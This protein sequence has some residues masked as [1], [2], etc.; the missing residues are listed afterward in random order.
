MSGALLLALV[1]GLLPLAATAQVALPIQYR[2]THTGETWI[3]YQ[4][5]A[6]VPISTT[7][8][9]PPGSDGRQPTGNESTGVFTPPTGG[10]FRG[11]MSFGAIPGL[12][13]AQ[14]QTV[15]NSAI[16]QAGAT[17]FSGAVAREMDRPRG[18]DGNQ[19][20]IVLRHAQVGAPFLSREV[21]FS[22]GSV[23]STPIKDERG[24][25]L[26]PGDLATYWLPEP[27]ST[28][29]HAG[30]GYY[31]SRHARLL[32][33]IQP[34]PIFITWRKSIPYT[35]ATK[36]VGYTNPNGPASYE[37][38]G[39]NIFLLY[40][41][42][43]VVSGSPAKQPRKM[44]WTQKG[45]Q[46]TGKAILVPT[47]RIGAVNIV[48]NNS[49]PRTVTD[50]F[51]GVGSTSPVDGSNQQE[52][53]ELRTMWYE[54]Q[55]GSI[56]AYNAEGRVFVEL[57]GDLRSDGETYIPLGTE[58]VDIT[59]QPVP[60]DVT[61]EL[62]ERVIPPGD[63][64]I[65][66][67]FPEPIQSTFG[68]QY[69]FRHSLDGAPR[70]MFYATRETFNLNDY[71]IHWME[72]GEAGLRWPKHFGRYRLVWPTDV[73][74]YSHFVRPEASSDEEASQTAVLLRPE[75]APNI[76]YQDPLDRPRAKFTSDFKFYTWLDPQYPVHRALL[77]YAS[78]EN[79]AFERVFSWLD[80]SLLTTNFVGGVV[81]EPAELIAKN[82]SAWNNA[83][84]RFDWPADFQLTAPRVVKATV[85]VGARIPAPP[86]TDGADGPTYVAG[87][88]H[89]PVGTS[90]DVEAYVDPLAQGF[91]TANM[92]A[93]IPV[94]AIPGANQLEVWWFRTNTAAAGPNAGN[95]LLGFS[96]VFW[97]SVVG[98][99]TIQ[100]PSS[101]REIVLASK[102]GGVEITAIEGLGTIYTQ[103]NPALDGYNPNEEHAI[104]SAG[105]PYATRDDLNITSGPGY[106]SHPYVLVHYTD[107]DLRP[108][109]AVYKVLR[110]KPEEGFV[111][112]YV[113]PA[114][115][116]LQPPLPLPFLQKPV[117]GSGDL[118]VNYNSEPTGG[119]G[120]L[121]GGW[122][123]E[124]ASGSYSNY[125]R[126]T[127][128][129]RKEN[130][131]VYRGL[132]AG[133][134]ELKAGTYVRAT[135]SFSPLP[136]ATAVA[137]QLFR[138]GIH[139]SRQDEFLTLLVSGAPAWLTSSGFVL[140]GTPQAGDVGTHSVELVVRDLYDQTRVT[141]TLALE[142]VAGG[143]Q[144]TQA[145]QS[146]L[147]TNSHT[148]SIINFTNRPPFLGQSPA[149]SN[150]FTL[151]YYY[152]TL[153]SFAWPGIDA[154]PPSGS[155]VP[156]LRRYD[157]ATSSYVGDPASKNTASLD[158]VY[159]PFWPVRDP[160][161]GSKPLPTLPYGGT[162]AEPAFNLPGVRDFKTAHIYY[163]QSI[164]Q[165]VS[166]PSPSAVLH[167]PT[168][169][170]SVRIDSQFDDKIP[171]GIKAE[172]Y[173][174]KTFFPLL[175]PH[176]VNRV[177]IDP[178][179]S[180]KGD[181]V[182]IGEYKKELLGESY[183]LLNVLRGSDL[184]AVFDL[185]PT[186]D[187]EN[188]PKWTNLV[189]A[190]ATD[191][192]TFHED[193]PT[194]PGTYVPD[195]AL[196]VSIGVG[197]LADVHS[198]NTAVDSYAIS[199]TG[200]GSGY[201]TLLESSGTAATEPGDPIQMHIFK[202]GGELYR[203]ELKIIESPNPLSEIVT[204]QHTGDLA[205]RFAEYEYEWKIAAPVDGF[206]PEIDAS[207]SRYIPLT[208]ID[209]DIPR[210]SLGGAGVQALGD[211]WV[212][213]RYRPVDPSHPRFVLNPT[214]ND[215]SEWTRPA[216]AEGWIK[217]VLK[218][219]NPFNQRVSDLFNNR[220]NTDV[221]I[222][223]QAGR[224]WEGDVALNIDTINNYGLIE[225][226]E[227][228]IRRG[229]SLSIES[230]Y[231]Y[232]PANDALLLAAGYINDL[233]MML[234]NEAWADAA[235][236]T[237]GIGTANNT[238][239]DIATSLFAFRG[240]Q[241]SLLDEELALL[242]GRDDFFLPGVEIT[243]VYNRLV[244]NY[245]RGIDAGEVVYAINYNI[246]E[247]PNRSPDGIIDAEDAA[248][249]F[250]QGH[251]DAY[252][253]Y[254][255]AMKGYY[256]LL[257]NTYF[258]WV[259]RIEAVNVL[260]QP[261]SVDY[262]D[263]RK[264][265]SAAS[266]VARAGRQIFDLTWRKDYQATSQTGWEHFSPTRS[267]SQRH[268]LAASDGS[269]NNPTR[270]WGLDHWAT[271]VGQ[272][273]YLNWVI[274]NAILPDIDPIPTHEGIQK[275][276]RTTV[277]ELK[278][279]ALLANGLQESLENAEGGLSPLGVPEDGIAFD[280]NPN[281]V[282]GPRTGTHVEQVYDRA[283]ASLRN[284]VAAFDDAK[285]VTRLM[286]SEQDS[287][288]DFQ[289]KV[290]QQ[291]RAYD[292]A[293]IELYG[294][295]YPDDIG[296]GKLYKQGFAGPDLIH[297][298]YVDLPETEFPEV[299]SYSNTTTWE[300][301]LLD[302]PS[303]WVDKHYTNINFR[304]ITNLT[305]NIGPHGFAEKPSTW[306]SRRYS[307]G[308]V[309]E[310]IS[311]QILAHI[312]L[313]HEIN[314]LAGDL[315]V[316][317]KSVA[318]FET[319]VET[320]GKIWGIKLS[321]LIADE[322]LEKVKFADELFQKFTDSTIQN[323]VDGSYAASEA[324]PKSAI[325]GV[326]SGGDLTFAGRAAIEG[327]GLT[328]K[329]GFETAAF[330]RFT[331]VKSL[332]LGVNTI[333]RQEDFWGI[334]L[335]EREQELR[336]TVQDLGNKLGDIQ[337]RMWTVNERL[338]EYDNA[339]RQVRTLLASG[340]TVQ[341]EREIHR[342][343]TAAVIQGYRTRD[344]A[345]RIF[346]NEK[347]ERYKN[348]FDLS[349]RY[350]LLAANAYDYETGLLNTSAGRDFT[351]R[352]INS[353]ALG[354]VR[355]GEP[356]FAGSNTGDPGLS[357][358]LAEMKA[359][360][361]V[362]RGRL[363]FNNPDAYGTT[364]SLR[365]EKL[366]ILPGTEGDTAWKDTLHRARTDNILEDADVRRYCM[367][368]DPGAGLPVPGLIL[369][370]GT[371]ISDGLNL[372]GQPLAAGDSAFSPSSF[373]TKIFGV[374]VAFEGYRG[375]NDPAANN[376]AVTGAGGNSA[377]EPPSWF[378]DATALAATP[379]VYL[380]PVGVDSM[381]SPPLGDTRDVRTWNVQDLAIPMPFNIGASGFSSQALYQSADSL[382]EP[383]FALRKHQAFRPVSSSSYF[384]PGL[385]GPG[386]TLQRSQFTNNRLVGRSVWNSQWKLVIPG[387]T[388]LNNPNEGLD[389]FIRT[390]KDVKL[391][392]T[393]SYRD[394]PHPPRTATE[395]GAPISA[396]RRVRPPDKNFALHEPPTRSRGR[397]SAPSPGRKPAP[398]DVGGD[399]PWSQCASSCRKISL[400]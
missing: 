320:F 226:Y 250:P 134:P 200:P 151:R 261:V 309:Q 269:T 342:Q 166:A 75:N 47:A 305:Y 183:L 209:V 245:T 384:S 266:A 223:T 386:G 318:V 111:F 310:A 191:V 141:N 68:N 187:T 190:L 352:I 159:R 199:A 101:T 160:K 399:G 69:A 138:Y 272:G 198:D 117:E 41:E 202:V 392:V 239:G 338:R 233:Y 288:V 170:K 254:L 192:E 171:A 211:N 88:I 396:A 314:D 373:A 215:W 6:G 307:P 246:Q 78:G 331:V 213:M 232:G 131:W 204:F 70:S 95:N 347:L 130:F 137:G 337:E 258:D 104:M 273:A 193:L 174:G 142:V 228:V 287:L 120:D 61:V 388:L 303:D 144:V 51:E 332:E 235:N 389:R 181:L 385:Y 358:A 268:Y 270:Y 56:Y 119:D 400:P 271:R 315:V 36:P 35:A 146:I 326:A 229:R 263:E 163:Q 155:I 32:Y 188:Y 112:D 3:N 123:A 286:R 31:W 43:Y 327:A 57:L 214:D 350:S 355:Q 290:A 313:R 227:T 346:R 27:Y 64:D 264:F 164:A 225:I 298:A 252:G 34:G 48:Y 118:A 24:V 40:T 82:L 280:S 126:F 299:W 240:Q 276:D 93:I 189:A 5:R 79:I 364:V 259:P 367:Q 274:G 107:S 275:V 348:L 374:G 154:P 72:E 102:L 184:Q 153:P 149:P 344:A 195:P 296:P 329:T 124:A 390:V 242:R 129:D 212:V 91:A 201:V 328:L 301:P 132:H 150:S 363:G 7:V 206:P 372:F 360:W 182:L 113:V 13:L 330:I 19:V 289:T 312:R 323:I 180:P 110:E 143:V 37:T 304:T 58:I 168:R 105:I 21:S 370:F 66:R 167:D 94:N 257:L 248:L 316:L 284:A 147:S 115:Q 262:L 375:M 217:R 308:K 60:E 133:I 28:N 196:T 395:A 218:G 366:R 325:F 86:E 255:T 29:N 85:N 127:Y 100:W 186:A 55:Q 292:I 334:G 108:S 77:R 219:I 349:A 382:S 89:R 25:I 302:L 321:Q 324:I 20:V 46:N 224:R 49:F 381:R 294:T 148:G 336:N 265:A 236:P 369:T 253:H 397:Q 99:Y 243:P 169:A 15:S 26:P 17:P 63:G 267:N 335:L 241:A 106:S 208:T 281:V 62:G 353:R 71:L 22:F 128:R 230:G 203:G 178:N 157:T 98:H 80:T 231:N 173:Q 161:D 300:I 391:H 394:V 44:Y 54:Q 135:D 116:M 122:S 87:H 33:A 65:A 1:A 177:F 16:L 221:S 125:L 12:S 59:K 322:I 285:D 81:A 39:A 18:L 319:D 359:D 306:A 172:N 234:G 83:N 341:A 76:E 283:T 379:Y 38:N 179:R 383:L 11:H 251:G 357:S 205:G 278:E 378:L 377:T 291:E 387:R 67:L 53:S 14:W 311:A 50:E 176:L 103:N 158:I 237:I 249:M 343:R 121:P 238:Y 162:L 114:G 109:M 165:D 97:P 220:V 194:K 354:V 393:Y 351:R 185:C 380:V 139:V 73:S 361:G 45:F 340:D 8:G 279:L 23:V 84:Q 210:Y 256:S 293:L 52:L 222:V 398:T 10:Q 136:A 282:V 368:V 92:G 197:G 356:Q 42:Q 365:T 295:P 216:L 156:Y 277:P 371:T 90:Y 96:S 260:G 140:H 339:Q 362:L 376:T 2:R 175:P 74:R 207:M 333:K 4:S 317:N 345:F 30:V 247:N 152:K 9:T 145:P 244:W 297:Y